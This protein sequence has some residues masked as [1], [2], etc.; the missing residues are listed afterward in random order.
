MERMI[1]ILI[2][3]Y[4]ATLSDLLIGHPL[5]RQKVSELICLIHA[6]HFLEFDEENNKLCLELLSYYV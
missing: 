4:N 1:N 6:L 5:N 2:K 3:K